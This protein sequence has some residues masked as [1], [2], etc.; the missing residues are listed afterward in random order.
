MG[1]QL[2]N[3]VR[4]ALLRV[5]AFMQDQTCAQKEWKIIDSLTKHCLISAQAKSAAHEVVRS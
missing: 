1:L 2:K 4:R 3:P 5:N